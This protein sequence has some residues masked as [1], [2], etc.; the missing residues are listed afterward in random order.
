M[1]RF[2]EALEAAKAEFVESEAFG[3][4]ID[5]RPLVD[6]SFHPALEAH[7]RMLLRWNPKLKLTTITDE[8]KAA[9]KHYFESL[10]C[11]AMLM[12]EDSGIV[13]LGSGPGFPGIPVGLA[14]P[15]RTVALVEGDARKS[16]FLR[17]AT[18]NFPN[19]RVVHGRGEP[20]VE[21]LLRTVPGRTI[22]GLEQFPA[23][24]CLVSRA[25]RREDV[26]RLAEALGCPVVWI[27][28]ESEV[29]SI[30]SSTWNLHA[31]VA[32]PHQAGVVARFHVAR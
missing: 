8:C 20:F 29:R 25:V 30:S 14:N 11:A 7:F 3:F 1:S 26:F 2:I 24:R 31:K 13:D 18:R 32:L 28:S 27:T 17:E 23:A 21:E 9:R 10:L 19:I 6:R 22:G 5:P 12:P 4:V 15:G 16:V